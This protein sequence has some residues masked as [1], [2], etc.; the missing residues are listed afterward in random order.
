MF[1]FSCA[2][3]YAYVTYRTSVNQA[4]HLIQVGE[5]LIVGS[6]FLFFNTV[7]AF[8]KKNLFKQLLLG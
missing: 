2:Y 1:L 5:P 4:L 3:A 8:L 7:C 6:D